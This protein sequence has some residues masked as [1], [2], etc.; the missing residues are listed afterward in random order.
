MTHFPEVPG[1]VGLTG[2]EKVVM[3]QWGGG[4]V[5]TELQLLGRKSSG[6][7]FSHIC[8]ICSTAELYT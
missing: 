8:S 2:Q 5:G 7:L 3:G 6:D 4:A 1:M